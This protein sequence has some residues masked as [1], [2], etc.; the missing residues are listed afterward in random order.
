[1]T[2]K[3]DSKLGL[4]PIFQSQLLQMEPFG[5]KERSEQ[6]VIGD[7]IIVAIDKNDSSCEVAMWLYF[8]ITV[9]SWDYDGGLESCFGPLFYSSGF[10]KEC[11]HVISVSIQLQVVSC[12]RLGC[13]IL[14]HYTMVAGEIEKLPC[15]PYL[16]SDK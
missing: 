13:P 9:G 15:G 11:E 3:L 10:Q 8:R 6:K 14:K 16:L 5:L 4:P 7:I 2:P 1:M 12:K